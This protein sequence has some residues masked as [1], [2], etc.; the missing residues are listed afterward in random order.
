MLSNNPTF[1]RRRLTVVAVVLILLIALGYLNRAYLRSL[2]DVAFGAEYVGDGSG[3]VTLV[4]HSGDTGSEIAHELVDAGVTKTFSSTYKALIAS[5]MTFYPGAYSL[6]RQMNSANALSAI[7]DKKNYLDI[8]VLIKEGTRASKIFQMLSD[9]YGTPLADFKA[10]TPAQ[11]GL[12]KQAVNLDGYLFPAKYTFDPGEPA[13]NMLRSMYDRMKVE[14][15]AA[16][17]PQSDIHRVLTLASIVQRE[18]R[19]KSDFQKIART[20]LNRIKIGMPLQSDATVSYGAGTTSYTTTAA[21]RAS[22]N[23]WN[24]YRYPGLP[25]GP[26]SAPGADA[27]DAVLHP[28]SGTW[29]YFCTINLKT[30]ETVFSSTLAQQEAAVAKWRAWMNANPG[31]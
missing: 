22:D 19:S 20:F 15:S 4:I 16:G 13:I 30:G 18:G 12:P 6:H 11:L 28:A 27:I 17:I 23:P 8:S 31:W 21:E 5:G 7:A 29:L 24:T 3:K 2:F 10:V 1:R 26:I 14:I 25:V 9:Q